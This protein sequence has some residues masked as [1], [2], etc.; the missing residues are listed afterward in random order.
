MNSVTSLL[1]T[2]VLLLSA[3]QTPALVI[4]EIRI[5]QPGGD[6]DEYFEL[7][8]D[9]NQGLDGSTYLVIGDRTGGSGVIEAVIDLH[10]YSLN[11]DGFI[12]VAETTFSLNTSN[13][14]ANLNFENSDNV[15]HLLVRDFN[16]VIGD[17]LDI[18]DDGVLDSEPWSAVVDEIALVET[19]FAGE[20][21]YATNRVGP[22]GSFVPCHVYRQPD[23]TGNWLIG[24]FDPI[25][26]DDTPGYANDSDNPPTSPET[27]YSSIPQIQGAGHQSPYVGQLIK[28]S[29]VVTAVE[30][31]G[32]YLQDAEGD[33]NILTSDAVFVFTGASPSVAVADKIEI[34]AIVDEYIPGGASTQNLSTTELNSPVITVIA[35]QHP[36]PSAVVIGDEGRMPP[37]QNVDD[38]GLSHYQPETD[39]IDFYE[40]LEAMRVTVR[41]ARAVSPLNRFG[42]IFVVAEDGQYAS[43]INSRGGITIQSDDYNP[44]R[45]QLQID[46]D[47]LPGFSGLVDTGDRLS[48]VHG[49]VNYN[50]GNFE[51]KVTQ[52]FTV[53]AAGLERETSNLAASGRQLTVATYNVLNLDPNDQDGDD[54]IAAGRFE[55]IAGQ[56]VHSLNSPDIIALQEVQDNSGSWNDGVTDASLTY[57]TL[58]NAIAAAGGANYRYADIAPENNQD[59]GQPGSPGNLRVDYVLPSRQ[60]HIEEGRV[61]WPLSSAPTFKLVG[62]FPFPA[63]D[64]RLVWIDIGNLTG[65]LEK[66]FQ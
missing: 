6:N 8:G 7:A 50:F 28:T 45:I 4:N 21:V 55:R 11:D 47:F 14:T 2:A 1:L 29:G 52:E 10:G 16:G 27:P 19:P 41:N 61:F 38:D 20:K 51:L 22:D 59:G 33:N 58:I 31:N 56:I 39:G 34:E 54:D 9:S 60:L 25:S 63:S 30:S 36:L 65:K 17:D 43:G 42:E 26:G 37:E 64:H 12:V 66:K 5:D 46:A 32:F 57:Q 3:Q 62:N 53:T 35:K 24:Q 40:S 44:E 13:L 48:D 23:A 49:V 18:D 15:T